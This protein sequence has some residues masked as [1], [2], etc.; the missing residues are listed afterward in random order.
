MQASA[1]TESS[2]L[3]SLRHWK[4]GRPPF[5]KSFGE[6]PRA[7]TIGAENL[8]RPIGVDAIG[9]AAV[10]DVL[11]VRGE[12]LQA[13]LEIVNRNG[14]RAWNVPSVLLAGRPSVKN[15]DLP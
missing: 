5:R 7:T 4:S 11:P 13:P 8:D 1:S 15:D 10:R 14:Y 12:F 9:P 2:C 6:S 3:G